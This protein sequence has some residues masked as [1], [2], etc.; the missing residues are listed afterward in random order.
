MA[1]AGAADYADCIGVHYN[2]GILP[3][4]SQ[5]GD[6]RGEYQTYYSAADAAARRLALPLMPKVPMCMT[7]VGYLSPE[8]YGPLPGHI[9]LGA[10]YL[11]GPSKRLG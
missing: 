10:Q 1:N 2:E 8:G 9:R 5:G 6:P 4:T 11:R 7:E 3:P